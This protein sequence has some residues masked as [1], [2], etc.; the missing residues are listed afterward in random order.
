MVYFPSAFRSRLLFRQCCKEQLLHLDSFFTVRFALLAFPTTVHPFAT[1]LLSQSE[2]FMDED[3]QF[4]INLKAS[5]LKGEI[6]LHVPCALSASSCSYFSAT[7]LRA[8]KGK[9]CINWTSHPHWT[10]TLLVHHEQEIAHRYLL[11][12][13]ETIFREHSSRRVHNWEDAI[14]ASQKDAQR[15]LLGTESLKKSH[16]M[17]RHQTQCT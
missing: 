14:G 3:G 2:V 13:G 5:I 10:E 17:L 16:P 12:I 15:C 11:S 4:P 7:E 8:H 1:H 9:V 6:Y